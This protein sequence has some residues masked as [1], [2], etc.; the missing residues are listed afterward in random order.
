MI[1][2]RSRRWGSKINEPAVS[3]Y[4][5]LFLVYEL[6]FLINNYLVFSYLR[7]FFAFW[8]DSSSLRRFRFYTGSERRILVSEVRSKLLLRNKNDHL[9]TFRIMKTLIA[10]VIAACS[11]AISSA[12]F[13]QSTAARSIA[14]NQTENPR[15]MVA[16]I[17]TGK[18]DV[19]VIKSAPKTA[20]LTLVDEFGHTLVTK[21]IQKEDGATRT[22]FDLNALP[23]GSYKLILTEGGSKQIK[24]IE[25]NTEDVKT[26]RTIS[27]S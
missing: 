10:S 24:D 11:F 14:V 19:V 25:L 4:E 20:S 23:D 21:S 22:R 9:K 13:A 18:V 6:L 5:L 7:I 1:T 17:S 12:S 15:F 2:I 3:V 26:F 16:E 8:R 27:L